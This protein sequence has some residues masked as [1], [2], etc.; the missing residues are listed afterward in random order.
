MSRLSGDWS[1]VARD[2]STGSPLAGEEV[3]AR[4]RVARA[5]VI[6]LA[7]VVSACTPYKA[8]DREPNEGGGS[9]MI[10]VIDFSGGY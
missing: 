4:R 7:L 1:R 5:A 10:R 6:F 2:R 9:S 3:G 8:R